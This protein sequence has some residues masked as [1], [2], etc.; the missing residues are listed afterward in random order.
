VRT[1]L[2]EL[3]AVGSTVPRPLGANG[4]ES[5]ADF[6][7]PSDNRA[8]H[9]RK[10]AGSRLYEHDR[11]AD[12]SARSELCRLRFMRLVFHSSKCRLAASLG[13]DSVCYRCIFRPSVSLYFGSGVVAFGM[14]YSDVCRS[15]CLH[16]W[17]SILVCSDLLCDSCTCYLGRFMS[18][19]HSPLTIPLKRPTVDS[20]VARLSM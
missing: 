17:S 1:C 2:A 14:G 16:C 3:I 12:C 13:A 5:Y 11:F 8:R 18:H 15:L 19:Q 7:A 20:A 6:Q 10:P 4:M 9:S